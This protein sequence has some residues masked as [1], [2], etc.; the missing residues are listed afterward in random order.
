MQI[1]GSSVSSKICGLWPTQVPRVRRQCIY[2]QFS[3]LISGDNSITV[4]ILDSAIDFFVTENLRHMFL[5]AVVA[6]VGAAD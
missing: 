2:F 3:K 6:L 4:E 1:L 5:L